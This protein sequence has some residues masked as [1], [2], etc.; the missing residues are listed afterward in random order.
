MH[1]QARV[2]GESAACFNRPVRQATE[3]QA[4]Q[5]VMSALCHGLVVDSTFEQSHHY[6][7]SLSSCSWP[8]V[9][10][11][12]YTSSVLLSSVHAHC[13]NWHSIVHSIHAVSSVQSHYPIIVTSNILVF[14]CI[15]LICYCFIVIVSYFWEL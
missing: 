12:V 7:M 6:I 10:G 15:I 5:E 8:A 14:M 13:T 11:V 9:R 1:S 3:P 2:S 4:K